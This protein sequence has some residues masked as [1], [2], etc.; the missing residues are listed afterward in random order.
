MADRSAA[1]ETMAEH[2]GA[3]QTPTDLPGSGQSGLF[4]NIDWPVF[5]ASV[6]L[7]LGLI[8]PLMM[9]PAEGRVMLGEAFDYLTHNLGVL[10]ITAGI[11][12]L[13]Y[14]LVLA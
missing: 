3:E 2:T 9:Y 1:G 12:S 6:V 13:I 11:G 4:E 14:L 7:L 8:V 10:Y 5:G